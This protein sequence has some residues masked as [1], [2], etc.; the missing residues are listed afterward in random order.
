VTGHA[1]TSRVQIEQCGYCRRDQPVTWHA[2]DDLYAEITE[3]VISCPDCFD[4]LCR[5]KGVK[6][7]WRPILAAD[8]LDA[9]GDWAW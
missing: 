9:D 8:S 5:R 3:G 7:V 1:S 2:D 4:E 6:L